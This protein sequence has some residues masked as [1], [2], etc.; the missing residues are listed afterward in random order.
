MRE[1]IVRPL[2]RLWFSQLQSSSF[3]GP[4]S[5]YSRQSGAFSDGEGLTEV[6]L[7]RIS[8]P[9]NSYSRLRTL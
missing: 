1:G 5:K 6:V 8:K 4:F 3:Y 9:A 7:M 2:V